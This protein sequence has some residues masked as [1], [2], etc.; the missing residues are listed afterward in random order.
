MD[1]LEADIVEIKTDIVEMKTDIVEMKTD[2]VE[3]KTDIV[4]IKTQN[5]EMKTQIV[6]MKTQIG[7]I[8]SL[9]KGNSKRS[10]DEAENSENS[11]LSNSPVLTPRAVSGG[12]SR[13]RK[14]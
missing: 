11:S 8:L 4:E 7:E 6:E 5:G 12:R 10:R 9:L 14:Q 2:I 1:K 13:Q 3:M